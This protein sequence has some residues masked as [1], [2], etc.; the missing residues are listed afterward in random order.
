MD[1]WWT[2]A[3]TKAN[4]SLAAALGAAGIDARS[5]AE[6]VTLHNS[7][8][9]ILRNV[10]RSLADGRAQ[11]VIDQAALDGLKFSAALPVDLAQRTLAER[12]GDEQH[13]RVAAD[14]PLVFQQGIT[15]QQDG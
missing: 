13:A 5:T 8:V 7:D 12:G 14:A 6:S 15:R 1:L 11:L 9:T 10:G 2:F 3:G 4:T